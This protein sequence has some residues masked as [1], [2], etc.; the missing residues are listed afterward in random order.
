MKKFVTAL[1]CMLVIVLGIVIIYSVT[2]ETIPAGFVGYIY[3][4]TANAQDNVIEGTSVLDEEKT[5]HN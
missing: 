1:I 2:H 3:D 5:G 4:R